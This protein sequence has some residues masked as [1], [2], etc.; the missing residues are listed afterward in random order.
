MR[1]FLDSARYQD[2][3]LSALV[4]F[5]EQEKSY[6]Q[7]NQYEQMRFIGYVL[8]IGYDSGRIITSDPFKRSVGGIP[9]G[10]FLIMTPNSLE[11]IPPHFTLLRVGDVA[12]TP[13]SSQIQQTY[14][15]LHKK[16]MPELD[17]W[18][19]G[20]LQWGALKVDVLGM[21]YPSSE[22]GTKVEFS[23]DL[24]TV[25]S[26]HRYRVY[27]PN[28]ELLDIITNSLVRDESKFEIGTV[29][30]TECRLPFQSVTPSRA[31]VTISARDFMG[32]R[33]AMFGKTRLG[34]S[35]IVKL[36]SQALIST[37]SKDG[38]VG[39]L[40]FDING[41]YANDNPQDGN[42]SLRSGNAKHCEV[43]A[44]T[45]RPNTPSKPLKLNFFETPD[46]CLPILGGLLESAG[47]H[48]QYVRAFAAT[49]LPALP[50]ILSL[51]PNEQIRAVRK[52]QMFWAI[53]NKAGFT[54]DETRLRELNFRARGAARDFN[55]G[56]RA[57]LRSAVY[58]NVNPPDA[59]RTLA[60]LRRELDEVA[61]FVRENPTSPLLVTSSQSDLFDADDQALLGFLNPNVGGGPRML[62]PFMAYHDPQASDIVQDVLNLL[63]VGKTV[64]LDLGNAGDQIRRYFSD[65]LS[66]EV[67]L[68]QERKFTS[69]S[70]GDHYVQLYFEEA[71]NLFPRENRD[72]TD[73]YSRFAKEGAK[74]HIGIVYSTQSPST[75]SQ[76]LLAQTEI[77]F[78]G[79]LSSQDET[80]ALARVQIAY[81]G[82]QEDISRARTPGFM[83]MLTFSH[84]FVIPMQ[85][86]KFGV[87]VGK[88][89]S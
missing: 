3:P 43:F 40:I 2:N 13:L 78:V 35:N 28:D 49:T 31:T 65:L 85:A 55:P 74:F 82:I 79:H 22:D 77:F 9:R 38:N 26:A 34:K 54:A 70:L 1:S 17:I 6:E 15:E 21:F 5:L 33:T 46:S 73:V 71:H 59:P 23:G 89:K 32:F 19:Q 66:R 68:H 29:R 45:T 4:A 42:T 53:L 52:I 10:S 50:D 88:S 67:F 81:E 86:Y 41:E 47:Q 83:R 7:A 37:T 48:A 30:V 8:D 11:G 60:E 51:R 27:S 56:F 64:I 25:V 80:R 39:Q 58:G 62:R 69:D 63:D 84:R 61:V 12:P 57:D 44:L 20:E 14:F 36:V 76:E 18:T 16:S 72:L 75:I 24:N 87:E